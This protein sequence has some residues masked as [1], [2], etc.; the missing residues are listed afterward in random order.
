MID[1]IN[2]LGG[3][4]IAFVLDDVRRGVVMIVAATAAIWA[5]AMSVFQHDR[6]P[7]V[8]RVDHRGANQRGFYIKVF[9][10]LCQNLKKSC[11]GEIKNE[12]LIGL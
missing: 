9:P 8:H 5:I 10:P 6:M 11:I 12:G 7:R 3:G 4:E 2:A 1:S